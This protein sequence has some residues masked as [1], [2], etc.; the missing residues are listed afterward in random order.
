LLDWRWR[1][2]RLHDRALRDGAH[3]VGGD[4]LYVAYTEWNKQIFTQSYEAKLLPLQ[5]GSLT[6]R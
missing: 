4:T 3:L 5:T 1:L 6:T 2:S